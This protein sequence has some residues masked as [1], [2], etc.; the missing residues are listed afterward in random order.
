MRRG[1]ES[2][3]LGELRSKT[4]SIDRQKRETLVI[5][6][7]GLHNAFLNPHTSPYGD[8]KLMLM[9]RIR[10]QSGLQRPFLL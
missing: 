4:G 5:S 8:M 3:V 7:T 6:Q 10:L 1:G 2:E 9:L